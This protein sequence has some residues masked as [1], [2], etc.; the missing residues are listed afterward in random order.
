MPAWFQ[1]LENLALVVF[2]VVAFVALDFAWWWLLALFLLFDVSMVGYVRSPRFG[3]W[4]Y[5]LVHNYV[6]PAALGAVGI[7]LDLRW[8]LFVAL[9]WAFHIA[10]DRTLG[11]GLKFTD[12]F[13]RTHLGD[14]GRR[15]SGGTG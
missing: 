5:N 12:A 14:I 4:T 1:R 11:Y 8:A 2:S 10:I 3:A 9:V 15:P 13:T 7:A 6:A